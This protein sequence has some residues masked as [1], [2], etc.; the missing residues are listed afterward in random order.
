VISYLVQKYAARNAH[1]SV[2][3]TPV[4]IEERHNPDEPAIGSRG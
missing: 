2:M 1:H 3:L 4:D